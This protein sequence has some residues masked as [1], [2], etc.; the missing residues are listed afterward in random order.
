MFRYLTNYD[1]E[2]IISGLFKDTK[3]KVISGCT[4]INS[5]K[6]IFKKYLS[7]LCD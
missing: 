5:I 7:I 6:I 2:K 1:I 4:L 3:F